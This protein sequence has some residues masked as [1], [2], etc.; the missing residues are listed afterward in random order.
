MVDGVFN[1]PIRDSFMG[2][3]EFSVH[4][5]LSR[6]DVER[7]I[8]TSGAGTALIRQTLACDVW[9]GFVSAL[10]RTVVTQQAV[11]AQSREDQSCG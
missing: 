11:Q 3:T 1:P 7:A 10:Q 8:V 9:A 2:A 6:Q 5:A 4:T